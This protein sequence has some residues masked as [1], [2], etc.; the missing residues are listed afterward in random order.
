MQAGPTPRILC[1]LVPFA[2]LFLSPG[3]ALGAQAPQVAPE[4]NCGYGCEDLNP[5]TVDTCDT[6]SGTCRHDPL[7]CDDGNLCTT[8][9]CE[10]TYPGAGGCTH[11]NLPD[12]TSCD[13]GNSCTTG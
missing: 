7:N 6:S 4:V 3:I 12:G 13:D 5:C 9:S 1:V 2:F 11:A 8:D 10:M